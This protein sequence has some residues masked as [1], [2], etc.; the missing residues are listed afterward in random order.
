MKANEL[1]ER[2]ILLKFIKSVWLI[3]EGKHVPYVRTSKGD[4]WYYLLYQGRRSNTLGYK[5]MYSW[6]IEYE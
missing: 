4:L 2:M 1:S 5:C 6:F 3:A